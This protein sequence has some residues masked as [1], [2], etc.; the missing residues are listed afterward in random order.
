MAL[1]EVE[2]VWKS[3]GGVVANRGISFS[4]ENSAIVGLIGPNGSGK[5]TLFSSIAGA[6]PIDSGS[7]RFG[8][9]EISQLPVARIARLGLLRTFQQTRIY[10]RMTCMEN[11]LISISERDRGFHRLF[12]SRRAASAERADQLLH[13]VGLFEQR[14]RLAGDL[15]FGQQKL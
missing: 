12:E 5:T 10:R 4:V 2:D 7:I 1:L 8:G 11:M 14:H 9:S 3:Y 13:F 15:S 6:H